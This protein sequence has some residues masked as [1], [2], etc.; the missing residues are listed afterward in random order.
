MEQLD[1]SPRFTARM[2]GVF[3]LLEAL[4][5]TYGQKFA[6]GGL[7]VSGDAAATAT[8]IIEHEPL[9][10]FGFASSLIGVV[11]HVAWALLCYELF[12]VVNRRVALFATFLIPVGCAIQGLPFGSSHTGSGTI[13]VTCG[14]SLAEVENFEIR[15]VCCSCRDCERSAEIVADEFLEKIREPRH[16]FPVLT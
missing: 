7:I 8:K 14:F 15:A 10:W 11:F 1:I 16:P 12:K 5:A 4:T 13:F 3:Q 2:A 9:F 6:L